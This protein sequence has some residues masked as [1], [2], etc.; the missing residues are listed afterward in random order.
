MAVQKLKHELRGLSFETNNGRGLFSGR[1]VGRE[2][3]RGILLAGT[4]IQGIV[5]TGGGGGGFLSRETKPLL[6]YGIAYKFYGLQN[7]AFLGL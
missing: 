7:R 3:I 6:N 4:L 5:C 1:I 2:L